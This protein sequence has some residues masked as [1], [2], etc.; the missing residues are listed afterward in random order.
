M[1]V[2]LISAR[3]VNDALAQGITLLR[4]HGVRA[5][6]RNGPVLRVPGLVVTEYTQPCE[7]VLLGHRWRD[8]NPFFH[9]VEAAW[10]LAGRD[11]LRDLTPYVARMAEYSDDGGVTQPGAYGKRWR[12]HSVNEKGS[13]AFWYGW[14]D[15]LDWVVKRLRADPSDRRCVIQMWDPAKDQVGADAGS[16]DVPCNITALPSI[17][18]AGRLNLTTVARSHDAIWGAHGANAV[19][20]T[21]MQEYLAA[22][23]GVPVGTYSQVS[24]NYHAYLDVMP[25]ADAVA[26]DKLASSNTYPLVHY[27]LFEG[28]EEID[29][30]KRELLI[31]QDL[32]I[33]FEHGAAEAVTKARWP[34]VRHVLAPM[35]LAHQHWKSGRGEERYTG[36]LEVL[37][38]VRAEDWRLAGR[39]WV[40]R[41]YVAWANKQGERIK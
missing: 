30:H 31:A 29:D 8:A 23:V 5:D 27:G 4:A 35:A 39:E 38:R 14:G 16:A 10:M 12:D 18:T 9:L 6:S 13:R 7:R 24:N 1:A 20:F 2:A 37:D 17:G 41:R 25:E 40:S 22:R 21:V 19:H 34:W 26:V 33:F 28:G 11:T 32:A 3:N 15:Q 36:A